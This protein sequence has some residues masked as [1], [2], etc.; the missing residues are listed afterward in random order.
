MTNYVSKFC[1]YIIVLEL[2]IDLADPY[3]Y[4]GI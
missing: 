2:E 3:Q 1:I 4:H